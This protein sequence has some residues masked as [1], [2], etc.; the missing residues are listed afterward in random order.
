MTWVKLDDNFAEHP[1]IAALPSDAVKWFHVRAMCYSAKYQTVGEITPAMFR[2]LGGRPKYAEALVEAGLWEK[3]SRGGWA[4]HDFEVYNPSGSERRTGTPPPDL[5]EKR[6]AAAN[7]R[8]EKGDAKHD[9]KHA[10]GDANGDAKHANGDAKHDANLHVQIASP[11]AGAAAPEYPSP[12]RTPL[13]VSGETERSP[14]AL[15]QRERE[16]ADALLLK[17]PQSVQRD[18]TARDE[19]ED[20]GRDFAGMEIDMVRAVRECRQNGEFVTPQNVR[21]RMPA[22]A[23]STPKAASMVGADMLNDPLYAGPKPPPG[24][25]PRGFE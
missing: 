17:C 14:A 16:M 10:N 24:W 18:P 4:I 3:T 13:S 12:S 9:A 15:S 6:R 7:A 22:I 2:A 11:R 19:A 8:W 1:K 25:A 23:R 21:K 20:F 5:S